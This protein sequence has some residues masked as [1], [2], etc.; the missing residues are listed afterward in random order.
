MLDF[1]G[2][3]NGGRD[4]LGGEPPMG[5]ATCET[6]DEGFGVA[7]ACEGCAVPEPIFGIAQDDEPIGLLEFDCADEAQ[8]EADE[9]AEDSAR[10]AEWRGRPRGGSSFDVIRF[11]ADGGW[12]LHDPDEWAEMNGAGR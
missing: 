9:L 2:N 11:D 8:A 7:D 5:C 10:E 6:P 3:V 1:D 4:P 12:T